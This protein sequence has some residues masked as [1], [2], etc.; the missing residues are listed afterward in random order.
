VGVGLAHRVTDMG[1]DGVTARLTPAASSRLR[2]F[3]VFVSFP[4]LVGNTKLFRSRALGEVADS[5][6]ACRAGRILT[7]RVAASVLDPVMLRPIPV[8]IDVAPAEPA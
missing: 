7:L 2:K 4:A 8:Q 3:S 5:R 1:V 6:A